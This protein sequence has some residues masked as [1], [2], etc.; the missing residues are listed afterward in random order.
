MTELHFIRP[1]WLLAL[2]PLGLLLIW[3]RH[4]SRQLDN[5]WEEHVDASLAPYVLEREGSEDSLF[6]LWLFGLFWLIS[7]LVI[8][9][10]SFEQR[11][12]PLYAGGDSVV[13][14]LDLSRSMNVDDIQPSR[15]E[16]ARFKLRDLLD[17]LPGNQVG[18]VVFSE[19]A[20]V[21][22]PLTD[23]MATLQAF[24]PSLTTDVVPV[25]GGRLKPALQKAQAL[26]AQA[27]RSEGTVVLLTDSAADDTALQQARELVAEG[28]RLSVMSVGTEQGKPVV[29][30]DG[31]FVKN[32]QGEVAIARTDIASLQALANE[33]GGIWVALGN[34]E[35]DIDALLQSVNPHRDELSLESTANG[36]VHR[37]WIERAPW[38]LL[39]AMLL[40][41][42]MF[43]RGRL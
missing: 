9:G 22:S 10:P 2:I 1:W 14:V 39:P 5:P 7:I 12:I 13:L 23:D 4:S 33:G 21:I 28:Y 38:L 20:Y 31:S 24:V 8:S 25:Q 41:L 29:G 35:A 32:L 34:D 18:L 19:Y 16:R 27:G 26:F 37:Q 11:E 30:T 36:S 3:L 42:P 15:L 43:R 6:T 40:L 17:R